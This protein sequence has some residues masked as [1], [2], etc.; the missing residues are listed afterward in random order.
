MAGE[1]EWEQQGRTPQHFSFSEA[2]SR[3]D[4]PMALQ[5]FGLQGDESTAE[6]ILSTD[7]KS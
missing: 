1:R 3:H 4:D 6:L 5:L 2:G 7:E